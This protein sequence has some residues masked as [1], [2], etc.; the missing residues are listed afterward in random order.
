MPDAATTASPPRDLRE[1]L[2]KR[3]PFESP[4]QEAYLNLLRTASVLSDDFDRLFAD[5]GISQPLF[6]VLRI[7]AGHGPGGVASQTIARH[8][9]S[10]GPDV[11]RLVDRLER[12]GLA[13]R[14]SCDRDRRVVHVRLT[15]KGR[16]TVRRLGGAVIELH[17][18]QLSHLDDR[19]LRELSR[20]LFAARHP[21]G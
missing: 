14:R 16:A 11:T 3:D 6:N 17:A 8:L 9:I 1:E 7:V 2:G 18:R 13:E 10:R 15:S 5:H 12:A 20:L 19:E 21:P 4:E